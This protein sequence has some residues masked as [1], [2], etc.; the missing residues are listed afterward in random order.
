MF[1]KKERRQAFF[2]GFESR[3][4]RK[5]RPGSGEGA[6][7]A[8]FLIWGKW[9]TDEIDQCHSLSQKLVAHAT[10]LQC[11]VCSGS[12]PPWV[13]VYKVLECCQRLGV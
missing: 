3:E 12:Y 1:N 9:F 2:A 7:D 10:M 4:Q 8:L 6:L 13:G 11:C 5:N